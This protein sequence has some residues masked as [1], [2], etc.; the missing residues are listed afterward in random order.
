MTERGSAF[1]AD[2][3]LSGKA[4]ATTNEYCVTK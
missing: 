2:V 1:I 4:S 3:V